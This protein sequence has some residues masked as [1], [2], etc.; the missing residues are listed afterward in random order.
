MLEQFREKDTRDF[1]NELQ[2]TLMMA[3]AIN[4]IMLRS[5]LSADTH[6][7]WAAIRNDLNTLATTFRR[8]VLPNTVAHVRTVAV[9]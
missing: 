8:P 1:V 4:R 5:D 9:K 3:S 2:N 7:E 6:T